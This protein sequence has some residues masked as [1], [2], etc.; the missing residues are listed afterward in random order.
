MSYHFVNNRYP[1]SDPNTDLN[2]NNDILYHHI[3]GDDSI[4][5]LTPAP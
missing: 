2:F 3:V 4:I 1:V 5:D